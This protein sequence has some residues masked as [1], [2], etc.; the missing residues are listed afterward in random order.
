M[1]DVFH[2][3]FEDGTAGTVIQGG[4]NSP[5]SQTASNCP[6]LDPEERRGNVYGP[7]GH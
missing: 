6:S 2:R 3:G 5:E 7:Q 1:Q 4:R